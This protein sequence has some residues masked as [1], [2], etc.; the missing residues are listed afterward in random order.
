[1]SASLAL[2]LTV[3]VVAGGGPP[4]RHAEGLLSNA[5]VSV[6][7]R[8]N[9]EFKFVARSHTGRIRVRLHAGTYR[10]TSKLPTIPPATS[11]PEACESRTV[12]FRHP[13]RDVTV[14]LWCSFVK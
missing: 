8:V 12:S 7:R 9:D 6:F 2:T 13:T 14:R 5:D 11:Q 4:R 1:M 3:M 10:F